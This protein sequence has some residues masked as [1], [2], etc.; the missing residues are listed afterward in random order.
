MSVSET[1][2]S[3]FISTSAIATEEKNAF[4]LV[5]MV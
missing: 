2:T 4:I 5:E 3:A 1:N